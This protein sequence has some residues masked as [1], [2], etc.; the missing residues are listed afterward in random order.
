MLWSMV[1]FVQMLC[2]DRNGFLRIV[3]QRRNIQLRE[4]VGFFIVRAVSARDSAACAQFHESLF[5]ELCADNRET[6]RRFEIASKDTCKITSFADRFRCGQNDHT[7]FVL[8]KWSG[9]K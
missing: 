5:D 1:K 4:N 6:F 7:Y 8:L 9:S 2:C 3:G